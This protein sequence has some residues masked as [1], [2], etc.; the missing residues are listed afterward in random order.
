VTVSVSACVTTRDGAS[1]IRSCRESLSW[2]DEDV[3]GVDERSRDA[4]QAAARR[5]GA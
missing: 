1:Q 2:A 4:S 5:Q 3:V